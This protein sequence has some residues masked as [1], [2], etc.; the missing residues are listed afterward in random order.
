MPSNNYAEVITDSTKAQWVLADLKSTAAQGSNFT[1]IEFDPDVDQFK[2]SSWRVSNF[3]TLLD[4]EDCG[5]TM[6]AATATALWS[7]N[8]D[9]VESINFGNGNFGL[10]YESE[11]R[12]YIAIPDREQ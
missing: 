8:A 4:V 7:A 2:I 1:V 5:T 3:P 11:G 12:S 6:D 10:Y 9:T